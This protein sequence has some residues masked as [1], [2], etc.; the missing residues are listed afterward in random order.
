MISF[1]DLF[2][3]GITLIATL[4]RAVLREDAGFHSYQML[5]AG[6]GSSRRGATPTPVGTSSSR[7]PGIL[8]PIHRRSARRCRRLTS[9]YATEKRAA[10]DTWG[11]HIRVIVAQAEGANVHKLKRAKPIPA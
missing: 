5:D 9:P 1:S 2:P 8:R 3:G 4:A 11:N 10:L 7:L 6:S